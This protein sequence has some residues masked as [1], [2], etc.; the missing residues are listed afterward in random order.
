MQ[1]HRAS[2]NFTLYIRMY[3]NLVIVF[4]SIENVLTLLKQC[5]ILAETGEK[6]EYFYL[7]T[8]SL[9][10][11]NLTGILSVSLPAV[12]PGFTK[13]RALDFSQDMYSHVEFMNLLIH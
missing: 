12:R 5:C 3:S 6:I 8:A 2:E 1:N 10:V 13:S 7:R 9:K 11:S 4:T